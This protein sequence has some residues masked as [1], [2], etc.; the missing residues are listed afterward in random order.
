MYIHFK[1]SLKTYWFLLSRFNVSNI[2]MA[3]Q[4]FPQLR[5]YSVAWDKITTQTLAVNL[6]SKFMNAD[7]QTYKTKFTQEKKIRSHKFPAVPVIN[8]SKT[9]NIQ[10]LV[11][12]ARIFIKLD[13]ISTTH[14]TY[15]LSLSLDACIYFIVRNFII[16]LLKL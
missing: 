16:I 5:S 15:L 2:N 10:N 12:T 14:I 6:I 4:N 13:P 1:I 9:C 11:L 7:L 3:M 8:V